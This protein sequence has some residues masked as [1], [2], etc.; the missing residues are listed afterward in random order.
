MIRLKHIAVITALIV[1][2]PHGWAGDVLTIRIPRHSELTP[3]QRLNREGVDAVK[4]HQFDKA[5][6]LFYKAYLFDPADP[7]TLN[8]LGYVSE[9]HGDLERAHKFYSLASIQGSNAN[10]DHSSAKRLEG[11]AMLYALKDL[12]DGPMFVNRMNVEALSL[13]SQNRGSEAL[14]LL[15]RALSV[16]PRNP[17]TL[18]NLGVAYE[19]TGE[20]EKALKAYEK[21]AASNSSETAT[22]TLDPQW[23]G[24]QVSAV[25]AESA[26]QLDERIRKL[27]AAKTNATMLTVRGVSAANE[28]NWLAAKQDFLNAYSLDPSSSFSLNNRGYVAEMDGD[29][30]TAEFFYE[31]ARKAGDADAR[32][33]LAT[34]RVAEGKKLIAVAAD[35]DHQVDGELERYSSERHRETGPIELT[36]R[37][38]S[39]D[40]DAAPQSETPSPA[41]A[42]PAAQSPV[43]QLQ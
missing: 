1:S 40:G 5:A 43:P 35:S 8:N 11:K 38:D 41:S 9:L 20:Y 3:V 10:I 4:K 32:V 24:K 23:R 42:P 33:G 25:A 6:A 28:N 22:I 21:A 7:F 15:R 26:R 18:N 36:P 12:Q 34:Q 30:E 37:D 16:D 29:L 31:K 14:A 2:A 39:T 17:F 27:G 19:A 13:L